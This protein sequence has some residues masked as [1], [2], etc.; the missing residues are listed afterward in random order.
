[1]IL[2]FRGAIL[3][4][5][6]M[7]VGGLCKGQPIPDGKDVGWKVT[8]DTGKPGE[9]SVAWQ[10]SGTWTHPIAIIS[11]FICG[12]SPTS[13]QT[14]LIQVACPDYDELKKHMPIYK[15]G[16][17]TQILVHAKGGDAVRITLTGPK[18]TISKLSDIIR[19][20]YGRFVALVEFKGAEFTSVDVEVM[21]KRQ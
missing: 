17:A 7:F 5:A 12:T 11:P 2:M 13:P 6:F 20:A 21:D 15:S 14:D 10:S 8:S 18:G 1:M 9:Q 19:D 3:T 16:K 4:L